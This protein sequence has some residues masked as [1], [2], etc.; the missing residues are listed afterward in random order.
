[1]VKIAHILGLN[2][3]NML[4]EPLNPASATR[5]GTSK[6][7][8]KFFLARHGIGVATLFAKIERPEDLASFDWESC[9]STFVIKPANGSA[10]KGV[11]VIKRKKKGEKV[12]IDLEDKEYEQKDLILHGQNILEGEYSTWGSDPQIIVEERIPVHPDLLPY[13]AM[14]TPDIRVIVF[15][16]I[17][18]MAMI[19]LPTKE[20]GGRANLHQGAMA[21]GID[22]GT[23]ETTY[24]VTGGNKIFSIFPGTNDKTSGIAIPYWTDVLK[25]A[26]RAANATGFVYMGADIFVHPQK[27]PMVAELNRAPGLSIQLAN[28]AGLRRRLSRIEDIEARS[29]SHAVKIAQSLFTD[30]VSSPELEGERTIISIYEDVLVFDDADESHDLHAFV[31]TGRFRSAI[32]ATKAKE[33]GL[34]DPD[35]LLWNQEVEGEGKLPVVEVKF[36]LKHRVITTQMVVAKKLS[37]TNHDMEIGRKDLGGFLV[38]EVV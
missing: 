1:M 9:G 32:A 17:P 25:T 7:R 4:Y 34:F 13:T 28:R 36:K 23:G 35:D 24:G 5:F 8:A 30:T 20:S 15:N 11:L 19:R 37:S 16:K 10:G 2:A 18:V 29:V 6:L 27:G 38:G 21:L 31:N 33:F 26:V 12:W 14:G 3:R 22:I